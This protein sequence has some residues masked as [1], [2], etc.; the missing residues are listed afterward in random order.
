MRNAFKIL[1]SGGAVLAYSAIAQESVEQV[2]N[3]LNAYKGNQP[4]PVATVAAEPAV[5]AAPASS[6]E[7]QVLIDLSA[8]LERSREQYVMG[9]FQKAELGFAEVIRLD[10]ENTTAN[11]YLKRILE[12]NHRKAEA[13]AKNATD[14]AWDSSLVLRSYSISSDAAKKMEVDA[15]TEATDLALKFPEITFPKGSSAVY[16]PKQGRQIGRAHV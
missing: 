8:I 6:S 4:A 9:E 16:Q 2:M 13:S 10:P 1:I 5:E 14:S 11:M 12:R 7:Q 15:V 3:D